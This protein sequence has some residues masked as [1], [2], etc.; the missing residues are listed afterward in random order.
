[1]SAVLS[2]KRF[3][4]SRPSAGGSRLGLRISPYDDATAKTPLGQVA[5]CGNPVLTCVT[6]RL[7]PPAGDAES[8]CM[9]PLDLRYRFGDGGEITRTGAVAAKVAR[10]ACHYAIYDGLGA[11]S[12]DKYGHWKF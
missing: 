10:I 4:H 7:A 2:W 11:Q 1:M 5:S 3:Y 8:G 12:E 9:V 6:G